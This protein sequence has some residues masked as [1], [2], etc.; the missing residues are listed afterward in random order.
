[1][2]SADQVWRQNALDIYID[3]VNSQLSKWPLARMIWCI[4]CSWLSLMKTFFRVFAFILALSMSASAFPS[5]FTGTG[6][7]ISTN[8]YM[9]TNYHV[10]EGGVNIKVRDY[11]GDIHSATLVL[12]DAS[13]DLA[14]LK[15]DGQKFFPLPIK[16]SS[17]AK[18]GMSVFTL[19]FPNTSIQGKESKVTEGIIS[20]LTG[21]KGEPNSYQISVPIQPG[22][23]GGPLID[24]SGAV[25]GVTT[26]KLS[27]GAMIKLANYIPENVNYAVKSNYLL[28]LLGTDRN[29]IGVANIVTTGKPVPLITRVE[30]AERSVVFI[31]V[32]TVGATVDTPPSISLR[33]IGQK[34]RNSDDCSSTNCYFGTCIN[35]EESVK[36]G[37]NC[38]IGSECASELNCLKG[39]CQALP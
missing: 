20:S 5:T 16:S 7:L 17:N 39:I 32:D 6:F 31:S 14:V 29:V 34:C 25:I 37:G 21:L 28:E 38:R 10:V 9:V 26:A 12:R 11:S 3:D 23:S 35:R 36:A 13:N 30:I 4:A 33:P 8:G 1:M 24:D 18:K 22:N 2:V 19:G 15:I 27:A